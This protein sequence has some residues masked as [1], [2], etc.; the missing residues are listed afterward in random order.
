MLNLSMLIEHHARVHPDREAIVCGPV[1]LTYVQLDARA[2]R[3]PGA[4]AAASPVA[5]TPTLD[6]LMHAAPAAFESVLRA[7]D[8]TAV[9]LYTSG[10]TGVPKGAELTHANMLLNAQASRDLFLDLLGVAQ[11]TALCVL[12]LFHSFGQT[13]VMNAHLLHGNRVVLLPR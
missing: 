6:A 4:P 13:A 10:T 11:A 5:G 9:I 12:P 8:D 2:R 7:P 1:R 3:V